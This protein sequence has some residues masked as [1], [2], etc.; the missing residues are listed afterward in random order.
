[1]KMTGFAEF[2]TL[3]W[4][5][6]P[7]CLSSA[8]YLH[9][10]C[11]SYLQLS[12]SCPPNSFSKVELWNSSGEKSIMN[13]AESKNHIANNSEIKIACFP[14]C[15]SQT[16]RLHRAQGLCKVRKETADQGAHFLRTRLCSWS[17]N[18]PISGCVNWELSP[19]LRRCMRRSSA[20][21]KQFVRFGTG[22]VDLAF[23]VDM[24]TP[25]WPKDNCSVYRML[26]LVYSS[27]G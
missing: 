24:T 10:Q 22:S 18:F 6:G 1:M 9:T 23:L 14:V 5:S 21:H 4:P 16:A 12:G 27:Q 7:A 17:G 15:Q 3:I 2:V 11:F 20:P 8:K 13:R 25:R 26:R 19:I